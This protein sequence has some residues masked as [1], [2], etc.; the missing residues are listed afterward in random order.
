MCATAGVAA[1]E[2][3]ERVTHDES[4][5]STSQ[6]S[7]TAISVRPPF[8]RLD[9]AVHGRGDVLDL[10]DRALAGP[11][12]DLQVLAG[13]GGAGKT[14]VA[15]ELA[16]R[17]ADRMPVWWVSADEAATLSAG[18]RQVATLLGAP[19]DLLDQAWLGASTAA[20]L[21]WSLLD[22]QRDPWLLVVDNADDPRALGSPRAQVAHYTGWVRPARNGVV[23]VTTR[24]ANAATWGPRGRLHRIGRLAPADATKVLLDLTG[25][26]GGA[27]AGELANRL[28]GL[29]LALRLAGL[30]VQSTARAAPWPGLVR[31]FAGYRRALNSAT[32]SVLDRAPLGAM[33]DERHDRRTITRTF[34]LS[35]DLLADRG[36]RYARPLLRLLSCFATAPIPYVL[37]LDPQFLGAH[38]AF[39]GTDHESLAHQLHALGEL[40]LVDLRQPSTD[41]DPSAW[42]VTLHPVVRDA[43]AMH[44]EVRGDPQGYPALAVAALAAV[45]VAPDSEAGEDPAM[46]ARWRMLAPHAL[47]LAH[48]VGGLEAR[49]DRSSESQACRS[50][51]VAGRYLFA[52]GL[53]GAAESE[54]R[55]VLDIGRRLAGPGHP[56][57][58]ATRH[59]LA[60]VLHERGRHREAETELRAVLEARREK[61]GDD[62]QATLSTRNQLAWSLHAQGRDDEAESELR[63]VVAAKARTLGGDHP[64]TIVARMDLAEVWHDQGR[65]DQAETQYLEVL[66]ARRRLL[67][68]EHPKTLNTRADLARI[69]RER[70]LL[71]QAEPEYRAVV[72]GRRRVLGEDHPATLAVRHDY[73]T[74]LHAQG[75][76]DEAQDEFHAVLAARQRSLGDASRG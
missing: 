54:L 47:Y 16:R 22:S 46:W 37:L 69:W 41:D 8:G 70:G 21:L 44:P 30:Y 74:V 12:G 31:D 15:L 61:L 25:G 76:L 57:T 5:A 10:L 34:E 66:A 36:A 6:P 49:L 18:M 26:R 17:A 42:T 32:E 65:H 56:D 73:A 68:E 58:L 35:L 64:D 51:T 71:D 55:A 14:T 72:E 9:H 43:N 60:R 1:G 11:Y 39:L 40:G 24:D 20:D 27:E 38:P 45:C 3:D 62:H 52:W 63:D 53:Y 19:P 13:M 59:Q 2:H 28:G 4:G 23:V 75:R 29:P 7:G 67:G 33:T 48:Y 50:A